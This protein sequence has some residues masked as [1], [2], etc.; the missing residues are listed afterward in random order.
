MMYSKG[1]NRHN[2]YASLGSASII[3][4]FTTSDP[5]SCRL[6]A[7]GTKKV[8]DYQSYSSMEKACTINNTK[9]EQQAKPTNN[10]L[11]FRSCDITMAFLFS[12]LRLVSKSGKWKRRKSTIKC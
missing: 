5:R 10:S 3:L 11:D 6:S 9:Q 4:E 7:L 12:F 2:I 1:C 8:K